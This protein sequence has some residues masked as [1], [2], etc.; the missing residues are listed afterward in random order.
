MGDYLYGRL[1]SGVPAGGGGVKGLA[2]IT[3]EE[4]LILTSHKFRVSKHLLQH[5]TTGSGGKL[6]ITVTAMALSPSDRSAYLRWR[7]AHTGCC[8]PARTWW[9][10]IVR[11]INS[12]YGGFVL[13]TGRCGV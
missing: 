9:R 3:V 2:R 6:D 1:G 7:A 10:E 12:K 4:K 13:I 5:T 8:P 11:S